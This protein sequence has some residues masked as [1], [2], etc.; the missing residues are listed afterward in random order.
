MSEPKQYEVP[1]GHLIQLGADVLDGWEGRWSPSKGW[2]S[3]G[4]L[5]STFPNSLVVTRRVPERMVTIELPESVARSVAAMKLVDPTFQEANT[6][7]AACRKAL[8]VDG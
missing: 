5:R 3:A 2:V 1:E 6:V 8:E 4:K 7:V